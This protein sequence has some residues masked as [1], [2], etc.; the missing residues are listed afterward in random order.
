MTNFPFR[1]RHRLSGK[2][3]FTAVFD[4][5]V[6]KTVGPLRVFAKPN[7]L[8]HC[9]LGLSVPGRVGNAVKRHKIKRLLREVFRLSHAAWPGCYDLVVVVRPHDVRTLDEYQRLLSDAVRAVDLQW[10]KRS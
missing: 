8:E 2:L 3:A 6:A 10:R 7:G 4:A 9:R 5:D 1:A